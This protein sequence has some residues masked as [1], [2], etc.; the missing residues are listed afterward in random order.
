[1]KSRTAVHTSDKRIIGMRDERY[2]VNKQ[3]IVITKLESVNE[4]EKRISNLLTSVDV[5]AV[6]K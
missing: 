1:M 2:H 4:T 5:S 6:Y 3:I